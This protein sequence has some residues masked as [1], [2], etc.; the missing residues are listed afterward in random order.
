M[1]TICILLGV[2][3]L[4]GSAFLGLTLTRTYLT[5]TLPVSLAALPQGTTAYIVIIGVCVFIGLLICLN[6]VM[7]GLSYNKLKKLE[8]NSRKGKF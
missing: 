1:G 4:L 5:S 8:Q 2:I 6:L 3:I 7:H